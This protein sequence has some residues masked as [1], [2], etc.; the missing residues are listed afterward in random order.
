MKFAI[1]ADIHANLEAFEAVWADIRHCGVGEVFCV[2]DLVGY[3]PDPQAV[4][5]QVVSRGIQCTLGNH[6]LAIVEPATLSWFNPHARAAIEKTAHLV[7]G[8][9][10]AFLASLPYYLVKH[11]C[12]FVHGFPPDSVKTYLF[13]ARDRQAPQDPGEHGR[14]GLFCGPF[15]MNWN[16]WA[17]IRGR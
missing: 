8:E 1:I 17:C 3:G 14:T 2:G 6:D 5:E 11:D 13:E 9:A 15:L 7:S 12:R 4:I 10:R 16:L